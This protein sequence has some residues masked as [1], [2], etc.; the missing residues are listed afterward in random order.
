MSAF[1]FMMGYPLIASAD[2]PPPTGASA[3]A[4][5]PAA[6]PAPPAEKESLG[7]ATTPAEAPKKE[8]ATPVAPANEGHFRWGVSPKLGTFFPGPT[9]IAFGIEGRTG[10]A[11]NQTVSIYGCFGGVAGVGFGAEV[12]SSGGA[13]S[14]SAVSYWYLGANVDALLTGPL[15]VGGG[16]AIGRGAWGVL[17]GSVSS[18]GGTQETIA[19]AGIMPSLDGQI[20]LATGSLNPYTGKRSGFSIALDVRALI[21]PDSVSTK[22]TA[23]LGSASQAVTTSTTA[24]GVS[25]M[26]MLGYDSR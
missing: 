13:A 6:S 14:I 25:P 23:G 9:T 16:A 7:A 11:L 21:A 24:L 22:Q 3:P 18:A 1:A 12:N 15:F 19:A 10:W 17:S 20:G 5:T 8:E 2:P 4:A 26:L